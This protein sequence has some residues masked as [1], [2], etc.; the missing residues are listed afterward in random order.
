[1]SKTKRRSPED[2]VRLLARS[3]KLASDGKSN[4]E[5]ARELGI[6]P[7]TLYNW[8]RR[9]QGMSMQ[10]AKELKALREENARLKRLVA[11][12]LLECDALR[13]IAKGKF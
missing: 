3:D 1:M 2:I 6:S 7:A 10:S 11:D 4:E 13:E 5:I 9:Y 8:R 12:Q